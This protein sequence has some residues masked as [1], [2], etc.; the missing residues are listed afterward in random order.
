MPKNTGAL[1]E[2]PLYYEDYYQPERKTFKPVALYD[3]VNRM[4]AIA[5]GSHIR[6]T[7]FIKGL[8]GE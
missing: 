7:A 8:K 4:V 6:F 2:W 3:R 5:H 1:S